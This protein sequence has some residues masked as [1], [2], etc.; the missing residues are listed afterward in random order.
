MAGK[1]KR[2]SGSMFKWYFIQTTFSVLLC[3]TISS[4][5][6]MF[7]FLSFWKND[8]LAAL[9][10]DAL[11]VAQSVNLFYEENKGKT[12]VFD[13]EGYSLVYSIVTTVAQSS[14]TEIFLSD[15]EGNILI[16]SDLES[17]SADNGVCPVHKYI[18]FSDVI[19]N[20]IKNADDICYNYEGNII[21][22]GEENYLLGATALTF[23]ESQVYIIVIQTESAALVPFT[24]EFLRILIFASIIA[25]IISFIFSITISFRMV[26]PLKKITAATKHYAGGDFSARINTTDVYK[27]LSQLVDSVNIMA[28]NLAVLEESRS[29]FVANVSHELKTPMT[30]ISGFVDGML[31]GTIPKEDTEKYLLIV[32][33][34]VKRLSRLVVAMLNMSKIQAG[35]LELNYSTFSARDM[36]I[37]VVLG[38]EK[39]IDEKNISVLGLDS[40]DNVVISADETLINQIIY[41]LFD[42]AVKF[43]PKDGSIEFRL[44]E[45]K[46]QAVLTVK[47]TGR[48]ISQE[49]CGLIFDR[50]YKVDKSRGLDAKSFGMGLYIVKSIVELHNGTINVSSE[51]GEFTEFKITIPLQK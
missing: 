51:I 46:K 18:K 24:T 19:L 45:E 14:S 7:F 29:S 8:R 16:C 25:I 42:N 37:N 23:D 28:D 15:A 34:E 1:N 27:E 22:F 32:S 9:N 2:R 43:T 5:A 47:N 33:N 38:F 48:G 4:F 31:D 41:N 21:G 13:S 10:D 12:E 11:S 36:V 50:F 49:E 44:T 39:Y 30:I 20:G 17:V 35:K 6:V 3:L 26:R 40:L